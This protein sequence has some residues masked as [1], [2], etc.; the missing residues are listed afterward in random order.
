MSIT[1]I[2]ESQIQSLIFKFL[3]MILV[4][5]HYIICSNIEHRLGE[6]P[7]KTEVHDMFKIKL[8]NFIVPTTYEPPKTNNMLVNVVV[9]TTH[10]Q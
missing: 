8:V 1:T 6:C 9:V 7:R 5:Q 2:N 4:H 10:N 3:L